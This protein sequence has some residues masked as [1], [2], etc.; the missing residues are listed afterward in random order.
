MF[1]KIFLLTFVYTL[2]ASRGENTGLFKNGT[3]IILIL[4]IEEVKL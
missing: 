4:L 2:T 3:L 1:Q